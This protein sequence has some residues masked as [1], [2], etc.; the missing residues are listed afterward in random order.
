MKNQILRKKIKKFKTKW[1]ILHNKIRNNII[2]FSRIKSGK[3][4]QKLNI[5]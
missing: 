1:T 4:D 3:F 5:I 2:I